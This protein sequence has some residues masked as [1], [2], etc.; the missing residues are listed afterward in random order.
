[1][2]YP[3][4]MAESPSDS[5]RTQLDGVSHS[6]SRGQEEVAVHY[7]KRGSYCPLSDHH[8]AESIAADVEEAVEMYHGC[9][10]VIGCYTPPYKPPMSMEDA[11]QGGFLTLDLLGNGQPPACVGIEFGRSDAAGEVVRAGFDSSLWKTDPSNP[12]YAGIYAANFDEAWRIVCLIVRLI[13]ARE[14]SLRYGC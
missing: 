6:Q 12:L 14:V 5:H 13:K 1:M 3:N 11:R 4:T 8:F 9:A 2:N 7:S 10:L